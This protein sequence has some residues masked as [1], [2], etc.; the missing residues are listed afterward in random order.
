LSKQRRVSRSTGR[1]YIVGAGPGAPGLMT[2]RGS[3]A[4]S[5]ADVVVYDRLVGKGILSMMPR[6][7]RKVDAGKSG[8]HH[9]LEQSQINELMAECAVSG[10]VVVRLKGGDPFLFGRGAEEAAFLAEHGIPFEVIPGVTSATAVPAVAGIPVT[11]RDIVSTLTI[12]TG[13]ESPSDKGERVDWEKLARLKSTI[14]VLMGAK[15]LAT[16]AEELVRGGKPATT[17]VAVIE[18]GTHPDQ[19]TIVGTLGD[20]ARKVSRARVKPP[21]II[22]IG[23]V[24]RFRER[25]K[26]RH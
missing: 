16:I 6:K 3:E 10:K 12:V 21:I 1:V 4:L 8:E 2:L 18:K 15:N 5:K 24:V 7:A 11:H 13:H 17:P 23:D 20:I 26:V 14:V 9:R 22:V 19:V 25:L